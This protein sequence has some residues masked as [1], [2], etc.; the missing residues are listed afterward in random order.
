VTLPSFF[1]CFCH[2]FSVFILISFFSSLFPFLSL[3]THC[4]Q[5]LPENWM[6]FSWYLCVSVSYS[7]FAAPSRLPQRS[8]ILFTYLDRP[9]RFDSHLRHHLALLEILRVSPSHWKRIP[10]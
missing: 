7:L 4:M 1:F 10:R 8:R 5:T 6:D 3:L 2:S 9:L